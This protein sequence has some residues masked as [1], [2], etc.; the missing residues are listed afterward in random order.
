MVRSNRIIIVL[1]F[2]VILALAFEGMQHT[3]VGE[4][5]LMSH[6]W[7]HS[8]ITVYIDDLDVPEHYSPSYKEDVLNALAYWEKGGNGQLEYQ[9]EFQ[10]VEIDN[11]DILIM[12]VDNL[13]KDTGAASGVAGFT[14]PYVVDGRFERADIVLE[15]GNYQ[16]YAW[17]QYGDSSME[18]IAAHELGHALGLG[19]SEDRNDIMYP[20]YDRR[21]N[22]NPLLFRST[23][24]ILLIMIIG[25]MVII[26]YHG[27]GWLRY[28]KKRR[29]LE[30]DIFGDLKEK[31]ENE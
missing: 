28:R 26:S 17:R 2:V 29:D 24:Y 4:P 14:R 19:H 6:P 9:P 16:G 18:D 15:T 7:D 30:D 1:I 25:A 3:D 12:W 23:W 8:P 5:V 20:S 21:E 31:D 11:A 27:S 13:E 10:V 22:L